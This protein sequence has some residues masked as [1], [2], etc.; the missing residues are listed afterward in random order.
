[1][2]FNIVIAFRDKLVGV[3]DFDGSFLPTT[4]NGILTIFTSKEDFHMDTVMFLTFLFLVI[5]GC[6]PKD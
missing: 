1:M 5:V 3:K 2:I 4:A 6:C